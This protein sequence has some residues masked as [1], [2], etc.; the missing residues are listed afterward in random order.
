MEDYGDVNLEGLRS[1]MHRLAVEQQSLALKVGE[2]GVLITVLN[3]NYATLRVDTATK[4]H[5]ELAVSRV[6]SQVKALSDDLAPIK[7]GVYWLIALIIGAVIM[8]I[9]TVVL[10][11]PPPR[12]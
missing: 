7:R 9:L 8:A 10:N 11:G 2:H 4:E 1:R 6:A 5:V 3:Q 12:P